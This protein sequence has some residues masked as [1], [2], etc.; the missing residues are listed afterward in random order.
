MTRGVSRRAAVPAALLAAV[1]ATTAG[2]GG[3]DR[4]DADGSAAGTPGPSATGTAD[5]GLGGG[6]P[7]APGTEGPAPTGTGAPAAAGTPKAPTGEPDRPAPNGPD[8]DAGPAPTRKPRVPK[9]NTVVEPCPH[10]GQRVVIRKVLG[11]YDVTADGV[12][13]TLVLRGCEASTSYWPSTVEV[14]DGT[15]PPERPERI[16]VLL[17]GAKDVPWVTDL[18]V[19]KGYVVLPAYGLSKK[20]PAACADLNLTYRFHYTDGAFRQTWRDAGRSADC[21]PVG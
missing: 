19:I 12:E 21:L 14:F 3:T 16:G 5:S 20:A 17:K 11:T 10:P 9:W 2:C 6:A 4:A 8:D 18:R 7:A 1:L 15:A 13:D